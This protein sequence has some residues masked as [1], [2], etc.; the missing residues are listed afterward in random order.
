VIEQQ[1]AREDLG[2][3]LCHRAMRGAIPL[4]V[5]GAS[6]PRAGLRDA[7]PLRDVRQRYDRL[8]GSRSSSNSCSGE[9]AREL[10]R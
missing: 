6:R 3:P 7:V 1:T 9:C 5:A 2:P 4:P 10:A 8:V